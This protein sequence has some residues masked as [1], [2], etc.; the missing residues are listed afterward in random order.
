MMASE[1]H[2]GGI[3]VAR[4]CRPQ[5]HH[6]EH[7]GIMSLAIIVVARVERRHNQSPGTWWH[8]VCRHDCGATGL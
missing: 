6:Q 5:T 3:V 7:D 2:E 4:V 1:R 8:D